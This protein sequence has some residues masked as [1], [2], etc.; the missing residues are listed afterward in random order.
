MK[1]VN[2]SINLDKTGNFFSY[3]GKFIL[4]NY[5]MVVAKH[6]IY[7][8]KFSTKQLNIRYFISMLKVSKA[9]KIR[10]RY[11]QVPHLTQDTNGKWQTHS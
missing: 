9:E 5:I 10:N 4:K 3:Q 11:N 6:Y 7:K 2:I 1:V 8:N